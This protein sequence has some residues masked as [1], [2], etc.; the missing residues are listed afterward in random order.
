M[1]SQ[2]PLFRVVFLGF[3]G[4]SLLVMGLQNLAQLLVRM[5]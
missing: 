3:T 5:A 1:V 2:I 4:L